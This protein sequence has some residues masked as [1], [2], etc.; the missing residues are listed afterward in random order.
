M[1]VVTVLVGQCTAVV[2]PKILQ[3][4]F[5][6][7]NHSAKMMNPI[8][9]VIPDISSYWIDAEI[10]KWYV[11]SGSVAYNEKIVYTQIE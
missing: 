1:R 11:S 8:D 6:T 2:Q 10:E 9:L 5:C 7:E 4:L 3:K